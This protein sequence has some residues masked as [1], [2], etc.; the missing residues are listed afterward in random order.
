MARHT[1]SAARAFD[2]SN[3][4]ERPLRSK[5][6]IDVVSPLTLEMS[7]ATTKSTS[8]SLTR[9]IARAFRSASLTPASALNPT[10]AFFAPL[11]NRLR[12]LGVGC[13]SRLKTPSRLGILP[14]F[15]VGV[16]SETAA[17]T[18][19]TSASAFSAIETRSA[20]VSETFKGSHRAEVGGS[21]EDTSGLQSLTYLVLRLLL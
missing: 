20:G 19:Q 11:R 3:V 1:R 6:V 21:G 9:A 16:K 13:R 10:R 8:A 4:S 5:I 17:G 18:T 15:F 14:A 2:P 12:T 7:F